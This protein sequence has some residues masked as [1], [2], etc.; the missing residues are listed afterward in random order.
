MHVLLS[1]S[2]NSVPKIQ[3]SFLVIPEILMHSDYSFDKWVSKIQ[4]SLPKDSHHLRKATCK[5]LLHIG[6]VFS[7]PVSCN[8]Q[9]FQSGYLKKSQ[10]WLNT[11]SESLLLQHSK[12]IF[13]F[14]HFVFQTFYGRLYLLRLFSLLKLALLFSFTGLSCEIRVSMEILFK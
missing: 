1:L 5:L 14:I 12:R 3:L 8:L 4:P 9:L 7:C 2:C 11:C 13:F 10:F 6:L